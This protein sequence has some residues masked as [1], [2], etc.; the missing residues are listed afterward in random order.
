[1]NWEEIL[2]RSSASGALLVQPQAKAAKESGE[3][4]E[5]GKAYLIKLYIEHKYGRVKDIYSKYLDK[6]KSAED[7]SIVLLSE[8]DGKEY[9]KNE[10]KIFNEYIC[11]TP[12]LFLGESI[13]NADEIIDIK[14]SWDLESY[15][16]NLSKPVN[17]MYVA[18][19][20]CYMALSGA[21]TAWIAYC[22][23][24]TPFG[25]VESE[26]KNLLYKMNVISEISPEYVRAAQQLENNMVFDDIPVSER[27]LKFKVDRDEEMIAEI[28]RKVGK[29]R[30]FLADFEYKHQTFNV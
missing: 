27:V 30:D 7:D 6:G 28:Y 23:V 18:Q 14:T 12:D 22:L 29:A 15:F 1:M 11:G 5:T 4:S 24:S 26:K 8:F 9:K 19:L 2:I 20:Q 21:H 25:L 16:A 17:P 3:L 10:E 13:H